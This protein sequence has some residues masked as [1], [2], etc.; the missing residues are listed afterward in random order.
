MLKSCMMILRKVELRNNFE[1][2]NFGSANRRST[3]DKPIIFLFLR[4]VVLEFRH[5]KIPRNEMSSVKRRKIEEDSNLAPVKTKKKQKIVQ[6]VP[7][8]NSASPELA[9]SHELLASELQDDAPVQKSFK[10]LVCYQFGVR[11][12]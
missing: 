1:V 7:A 12:L 4:A 3:F 9:Q 2:G 5:P 11:R 6:T 8:P 10:D